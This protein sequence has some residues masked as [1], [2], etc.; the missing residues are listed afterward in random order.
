MATSA[1]NASTA[2]T[3]AATARPATRTLGVPIAH[4]AFTVK[5]DGQVVPSAQHLVSVTVQADRR[6]HV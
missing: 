4:R 1:T 3:P 6:A 5:V 2:A